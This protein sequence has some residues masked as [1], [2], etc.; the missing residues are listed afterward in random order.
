M[1]RDCHLLER[2]V[3]GLVK[4]FEGFVL[5]GEGGLSVG[6]VFGLMEKEECYWKFI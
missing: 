2:Y 4:A 6:D 5:D 3:L 1:V